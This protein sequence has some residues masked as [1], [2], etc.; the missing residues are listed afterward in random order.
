MPAAFVV[1]AGRI[2]GLPSARALMVTGVAIS[3]MNV[4]SRIAFAYI[5]QIISLPLALTVM[6]LALFAASKLAYVLHPE[7]AQEHAIQR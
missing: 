6:G 7:K 1:A 3:L 5:S 4:I 2:P